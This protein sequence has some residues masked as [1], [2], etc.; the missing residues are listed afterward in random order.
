MLAVLGV[1][2]TSLAI[3]GLDEWPLGL[4]YCVACRQ[5]FRTKGVRDVMLDVALMQ[6]VGAPWIRWQRHSVTA[7][8]TQISGSGG[9]VSSYGPRLV[10]CGEFLQLWSG[11]T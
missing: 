8:C 10:V 9:M 11:Q 3:A 7:V 6:C 4:F 5:G 2:G 1:H